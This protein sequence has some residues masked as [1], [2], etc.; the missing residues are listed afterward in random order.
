MMRF[1]VKTVIKF[2]S[3]VTISAPIGVFLGLMIHSAIPRPAKAA[4][5]VQ[6]QEAR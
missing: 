1:S 6:K 2:V 5:G 4:Q 3:V